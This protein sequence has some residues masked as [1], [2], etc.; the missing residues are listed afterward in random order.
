[1]QAI[2]SLPHTCNKKALCSTLQKLQNLRRNAPSISKC[3]HVALQLGLLPFWSVLPWNS[4]PTAMPCSYQ[5]QHHWVVDFIDFIGFNLEVLSF[6]AMTV[7][8]L[9]SLGVGVPDSGGK[10]AVATTHITKKTAEDTWWNPWHHLKKFLHHKVRKPKWIVTNTANVMGQPPACQIYIWSRA[11]GNLTIRSQAATA[12]F[13]AVKMLTLIPVIAVL[14][15]RRPNIAMGPYGIPWPA[16]H[17]L[18]CMCLIV[19]F[20]AMWGN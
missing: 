16:P 1:M 13:G 20:G 11:R 17:H 8:L 5:L 7:S 9:G 14:Y 15:Y 10:M 4:R 2:V 18:P 12:G 6:I 19:P 3:K